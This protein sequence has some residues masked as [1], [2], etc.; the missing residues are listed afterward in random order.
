MG[1][2][3]DATF[4][5]VDLSRLSSPDVVELLDFDTIFADAVAR[6]KVHMPEFETRESDPATKQLLVLS[7]FAQLLRQRINDAARAV[8]PAHGDD[9]ELAVERHDV[10]RV[11]KVRDRFDEPEHFSDLGHLQPIYII[12]N[13]KHFAIEQS[14]P[15]SDLRAE[16]S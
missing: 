13:H 14:Q 6:M 8:M 1:I 10:S 7:Y 2:M 15:R 5:A 4:T 9:G 12:H 3:A 11:G 16:F